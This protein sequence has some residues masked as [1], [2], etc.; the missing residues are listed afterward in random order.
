MRP[1]H[2]TC[3]DVAH[4]GNGGHYYMEARL[5]DLQAFVRRPNHNTGDL[6][7][8]TSTLI[9]LITAHAHLRAHPPLCENSNLTMIKI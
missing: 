2:D 3:D 6:E 9:D 1:C 8:D 7:H 4:I 5:I